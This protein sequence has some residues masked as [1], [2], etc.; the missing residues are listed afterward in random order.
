MALGAALVRSLAGLATVVVAAGLR[1]WS[2]DRNGFGN[3]YY[4]AAVRSMLKTPSNFFFVAFDPTGFLAV[5]KPPLAFW[6]QAASAWLFGYHGLS[7]LVPQAL[8]GVG[9]VA[10]TLHLV[11]RAFGA[12][13][14]VLAGLFLAVT[15]VCVADDRTNLPDSTLLFVLLLAA[16]ALSHAVETGRWRSLLASAALVGAGY[17]VK[18]TAGLFIVPAF[19]L[20]W[21]LAAPGSIWVRAGR[22]AVAAGVAAVAALSWSVVV[23]LTPPTRR[24]YVGGSRWNSA[25]HLGLVANTV[26]KILGRR[27]PT[28]STRLPGAPQGAEPAGGGPPGFGGRPGPLRFAE[29][30]WAGEITWLVPLAVVGTAMGA[31][32]VFGRGR[33]GP[34]LL[35]WAGWLVTDWAVFSFVRGHLHEYY[36]NVMGPPVAALAGASTVALYD[37]WRRGG[38]RATMLPLAL[39]VTLAWQGLV[40]GHFPEWQHKL[41]PVMLAMAGT[42]VLGLV[43]ARVLRRRGA[44]SYWEPAWMAVAVVSLLVAPTAWSLMP[45]LAR[46]GDRMNPMA[47]PSILAPRPAGIPFMGHPPFELDPRG[48]RKLA[49]FLLANRH[50]EAVVLAAMD[51][52][53]AAPLIVEADLPA[54][55]LGGFSGDDCVFSPAEFEAMVNRGQLRFVLVAPGQGQGNPAILDWVRRHG[56]RVDPALWRVDL[57]DE[58]P[59]GNPEPRA[60]ADLR[61]F[62]AELRRWTDLYDLRSD[63]GLRRP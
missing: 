24:P 42:G 6:L 11:G 36:S 1:L 29:P 39:A 10:L 14:G 31:A 51:H 3:P 59:G 46:G 21:L 8:L 19:C 47:D 12:A 60:Q 52:F 62:F 2:L 27:G 53:L 41:W 34:A 48:T 63:L 33:A 26:D 54:I 49:A 15:P 7:L 28:P 57:P 30:L 58:P 13:S 20:V 9:S 4:A 44:P 22:L 50:G 37:G 32:S 45:I 38:W 17:N 61:P 56:R 5:D 23:D 40:L 25:L 18:L 16:W 43:G 35:L 55:S